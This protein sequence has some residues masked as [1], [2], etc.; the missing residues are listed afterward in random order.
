MQCKTARFLG[1]AIGFR[2]C[3]NTKNMPRAYVGEID[4]FGVH[5]PDIDQVFLVPIGDVPARYAYLRLGPTRNN[6]SS[7]IRWACDYLVPPVDR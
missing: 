4:Y 3:S 7:R 1:D 5:A 6:Q 2:T